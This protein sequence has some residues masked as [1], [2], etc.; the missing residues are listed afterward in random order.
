MPGSGATEPKK[1]RGGFTATIQVNRRWNPKNTARGQFKNRKI[2][3]ASSM[4]APQM[5]LVDRRAGEK[6]ESCRFPVT[7]L[8][9]W[10]T[11]DLSLDATLASRRRRAAGG[12]G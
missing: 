8:V 7:L 10:V 1:T 4:H 12:G 9:S 2:H 6:L 3:P 11:G 5:A